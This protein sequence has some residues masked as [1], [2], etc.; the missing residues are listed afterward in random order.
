MRATRERERETDVVCVCAGAAPVSVC[1]IVVAHSRANV[2]PQDLPRGCTGI[3][4][5]DMDIKDDK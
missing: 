4:V 2:N 5:A 1:D 3:Q